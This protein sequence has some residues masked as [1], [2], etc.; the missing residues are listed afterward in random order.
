M[1]SCSKWSSRAI[2]EAKR[3]EKMGKKDE[4]ALVTIF[5]VR[6]DFWCPRL[7]DF[8]KS[9]PE[10]FLSFSSPIIRFDLFV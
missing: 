1:M 3:A 5:Q 10:S 7:P 8:E 9:T 6:L 2:G 4:G